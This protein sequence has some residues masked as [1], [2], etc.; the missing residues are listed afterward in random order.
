MIVTL[1]HGLPRVEWW[2][3]RWRFEAYVDP[4]CWMVGVNFG[5]EKFNLYFHI[6]PFIIGAWRDWNWRDAS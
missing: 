3:R 2:V 1:V 4:T 5:I 6:G